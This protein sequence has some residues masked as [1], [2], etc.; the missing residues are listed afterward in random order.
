LGLFDNYIILLVQKLKD[1]DVFGVS[2]DWI[3]L[4]W[5]KHEWLFC[6]SYWMVRSC[7]LWI[8]HCLSMHNGDDQH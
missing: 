6:A 4:L 2:G 7:N 5:I 3:M 8:Y 1:C